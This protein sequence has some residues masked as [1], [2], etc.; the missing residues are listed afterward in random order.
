[1]RVHTDSRAAESAWA[2]GA[3]AYTVGRD[4]VFGAGQYAPG[5]GEG[6][7]LLAHE[8]THVI[9]QAGEASL[10]SD[11]AV[12]PAD[13]G[14]EREAEAAGEA[15]GQGVAASPHPTSASLAVQ[16]VPLDDDSPFPRH[17]P[18]L[19]GA[20]PRH[21]GPTLSYRES[22]EFSRCLDIFSDQIA[23]PCVPD[24]PLAWSDFTGTPPASPPHD[25]NTRPDIRLASSTTAGALCSHE[26]LGEPLQSRLSF[27]AFLDAAAS[28]VVPRVANASDPAQ[29]TCDTQIGQCQ[30][31]FDAEAAAGRTGG[32][33]RLRPRGRCAAGI[34]PDPSIVAN[35]RGDCATLLAPECSR[36]AQLES[37]RL[38]RHEQLHFDIGCV[39]ARKA[40]EALDAGGNRDLLLQNAKSLLQPLH[41]RYD[42]ETA[43]GCD[44]T[45]QARWEQDVAQGLPTVSVTSVPSRQRR[46]RSR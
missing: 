12:Q 21:D 35:S 16:R 45:A 20:P 7:R 11:L 31:F 27:Q 34:H 6:R 5:S 24:R 38:L 29:N 18:G 1:V 30:Q 4:V 15:I 2:V 17:P 28:W 43:H 8:L 46:R 42:R 32:S 13:H 37:D 44:A 22:I 33:F 3:L 23:L 41:D 36:V 25:A 19:E 39:L 26:V 40:T 9:Q 10:A 14:A